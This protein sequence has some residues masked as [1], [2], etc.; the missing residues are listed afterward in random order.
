MKKYG[1]F[2]F[3]TA[4]IVLLSTLSALVSP[5]MIQM[6]SA[7][8]NGITKGRIAAI[9]IV[10]LIS[11]LLEIVCFWIR[12]YFAKNFNISNCKS[13][14]KA[15]F[16]MTYDK[17]NELGTLSVTA[18]IRQAVNDFYLYYV[19]GKIN[20]IVSVIILSCILI[21]TFFYNILI[22]A[23]MAFLVFINIS[24]YKMLNKELLKRSKKLQEDTSSGWQE[25]NQI[26]ANTDYVKQ[27]DTHE[28]LFKQMEPSFQKIYTSMRDINLFAQTVSHAIVVFNNLCQTFIMMFL[29]FNFFND[30]SNVYLLI[31]YTIIMPLF[32][33]H[34][35]EIV[36][37]NLDKRNLC[38]SKDFINDMNQNQE[39]SGKERIKEIVKISFDFPQWKNEFISFSPIK[40]EFVKGDI[41]RVKGKSGCGKSTLMKFLLKFWK[42]EYIKLND[43]AIYT[44]DNQDCRRLINYVPQQS[45]IIKGTLRENLF[46]GKPYSKKLEDQMSCFPILES[47]FRSKNM[48]SFIMENGNNLSGGEKQKIAFTREFFSDS[49]VFIFDEI[50]SNIDA[51]TA[52][53][54]YQAIWDFH[55]DKI[56]FIISHDNIADN[57]CNKRI[58]L[59]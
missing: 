1:F 8:E 21:F 59:S 16:G 10:M 22:F 14:F 2:I 27:L 32:S 30:S 54:I 34:L 52:K 6:W 23:I 45:P 56:I 49:D 9:C 38:V 43:K 58:V 36:N 40:Q 12:E 7:S 20:L 18:K 17:I 37:V 53:E 5:I 26:A 3:I 57:I 47:V 48:D 29:V 31:I 25:I 42:T 35:S 46:L 50:T 39:N 15:F 41:I 19:N 4:L 13:F 28:Y 55:K 51:E 11:G 24:G 33:S 44:I